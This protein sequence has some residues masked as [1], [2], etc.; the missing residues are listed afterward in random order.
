MPMMK[1][2]LAGSKSFQIGTYCYG[3]CNSDEIQPSYNTCDKVVCEGN[4]MMFV[5]G[6][7]AGDTAQHMASA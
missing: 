3:D 5:R 1:R 6:G 7:P 2:T 4:S